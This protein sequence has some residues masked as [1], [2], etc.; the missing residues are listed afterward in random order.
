MRDLIFVSME[1]WDEIWRRNQFVVAE[2]ARR[3]PDR[4]IL[5]VGLARDFSHALRK[6]RLREIKAPQTVCAPDLTNVFLT[7]ASKFLPNTLPFCRKINEAAMRRHVRKIARDLGLKA[8]VLWLNP[9]SAV[10]MIGQ[11]NE[12]GALYDIT[13]DWT[14]LTQKAAEKRL[15]TQQDDALCRRANA[16]VVCSSRL[17]ELKKSRAK[18]LFLV[19]NG[20]DVAHYAAVDNTRRADTQAPVFG[21]T[22]SIH[23]DRVD[24]DRVLDLARAFP[25]GRVV[26][27]GPNMLS[28]AQTSK[29]RAQPNIELR[30]AISYAQIPQAMSQFDVCVVPHVESAFTESLNPIKL[31]EYLAAGKPIVSTNLAGFRDFPALCRIA[32][33]RDDFLAACREAAQEAAS[34]NASQVAARQAEA[35]NNSWTKRVDQIVEILNEIG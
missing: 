28:E 26:L 15:V 24:T 27:I 1:N 8:P 18:E 3:F 25:Q 20:V 6:G 30:G 29:L 23:A 32:S 21:Y 11:M 33:S 9:H 35:S 4:K 13:D 22:G 34:D 2:L 19:P 12:R 17:F 5:F 31:W 14:Q 16:V 10:H 7:N